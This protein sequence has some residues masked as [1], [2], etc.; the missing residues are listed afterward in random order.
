MRERISVL[1]LVAVLLL[2]GLVLSAQPSA[3]APP[4]SW[5]PEE[6]DLGVAPGEETAALMRVEISKNIPA[7]RLEVTP[8]LAPFVASIEP[9]TLP[10]L[11]EG[12]EVMVRIVFSVP[13]TSGYGDIDGTL[14]LRKAQGNGNSTQARPLPIVLTIGDLTYPPDPG[15]L[16][17]ET[18][19]GVDSDRDGVRDDV[20][21]QIA[22]DHPIEPTLRALLSQ[23]ARMYQA[24][25]E[26]EATPENASTHTEQVVKALYCAYAL[27]E[28]YDRIKSI[29]PI[30]LNSQLRS[31]RALQMSAEASGTFTSLPNSPD[32]VEHCEFSP[33]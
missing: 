2:A 10:A 6:I 32:L 11:S 31:E 20:Q 8:S 15:E 27:G 5:L 17:G 33:L 30:I 12:D 26:V 13:P 23:A 3:A 7:T 18:L 24:S 1:G 29:R 22:L 16:G 28:T 19:E 14:K 9:T 4:V 25:Y 21:R